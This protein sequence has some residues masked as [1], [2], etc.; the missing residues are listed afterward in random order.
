MRILWMGPNRPK[1]TSVPFLTTLTL[2]AIS[3]AK[4][5]TE[6]L[7]KR[8]LPD[9]Y[10]AGSFIVEAK[11]GERLE[12]VAAA[13]KE[14]GAHLA[15]PLKEAEAVDWGSGHFALPAG[16]A[17]T[18]NLQYEN[19]DFDDEKTNEVLSRL[20]KASGIQLALAEAQAMATPIEENDPLKPNQRFLDLIKR[21][22][23]CES[24]RP[25][26]REIVVAVLDSGV[27]VDHPD[28]A[29]AIYRDKS[30]RIIGANFVGSRARMPHDREFSDLNGHGTHVAGLIAA[31]ANNG[32]GIVGVA[33]CANV[34]IMP[35]RVLNGLGIGTGIEIDRGVKWAADHGA[36]IINLSL[37]YNSIINSETFSFRSSLYSTLSAQDVVVF[38]AS[39]NDGLTNGQTVFGDYKRYS[40][41]ASFDD[42]IAVAA[43]DDFGSVTSFS[44]VGDRVD[45]AAPGYRVLSTIPG[46]YRRLSGTSMASPIASGGYALALASAQK[47]MDGESPSDRITVRKALKLLNSS[48]SVPIAKREV[49]S[50]GVLDLDALI[51]STN[52]SFLEVQPEVPE[53]LPETP[54]EPSVGPAPVAKPPAK[55]FSF[56]GLQDFSRPTWP[57]EIKV[58]NLPKNTYGIYFY[59]GN[60]PFSF[61]KAYP[62]SASDFVELSD[63][64]EWYLYGK[65]KLSSYAISSEGQILKTIEVTI[66]GI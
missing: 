9:R 15:C 39:G 33:S 46:S 63:G 14:I 43:T 23:A 19:C 42:V 44:N 40:F 62:E 24:T 55:V 50:G 52:A 32:Q 45:V 53:N 30:G 41:P 66:Y 22:A 51:S 61:S 36:D 11:G 60:W 20:T 37:G 38:A 10:V 5:K 26:Q 64:Y 34:K 6:A 3:C 4:T 65:A 2:F 17:H 25:N 13:A 29:D 27:D 58:Q 56:V 8:R 57:R 47:G 21:D 12:Q 48:T 1:W 18:I 54:P 49:D 28:L 31:T 35:V 7:D 59:W 16:L